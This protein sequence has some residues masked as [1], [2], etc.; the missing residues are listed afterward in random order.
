MMKSFVSSSIVSRGAAGSNL[1]FS[2][3]REFLGIFQES[4]IEQKERLVE[5]EEAQDRIIAERRWGG[6]G[7]SG[8]DEG[9]VVAGDVAYAARMI[10]KQGERIKTLDGF[11]ESQAGILREYEKEIREKGSR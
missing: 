5:A 2:D 4:L 1:F 9:A 11:Y 10:G 7:R 3:L 6:W 8:S